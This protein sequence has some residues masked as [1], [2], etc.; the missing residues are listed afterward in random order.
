MEGLRALA[1]ASL[2]DQKFQKQSPEYEYDIAVIDTERVATPY[3]VAALANDGSIMSPGASSNT[4]R[5]T[6]TSTS[7]VSRHEAGRRTIRLQELPEFLDRP[8]ALRLIMLRRDEERAFCIARSGFDSIWAAMRANP[9]AL[10][11]V[12]QEYDGYHHFPS[13]EPQTAPTWFLGMSKYAL[14][15]TFDCCTSSTT[16]LFLHRKEDLLAG[17]FTMLDIYKACT[18][19]PYLIGFAM[20]LHTLAYFSRET[21]TVE[22]VKTQTIEQKVGFGPYCGGSDQSKTRFEIQEVTGWSR[23]VGEVQGQ[24]A[25][26]HRHLTSI[27]A[28]L[29]AL[30]RREG[31]EMPRF[32]ASTG[33]ACARCLRDTDML[34]EALPVIGSQL[35]TYVDFVEYLKDRA[36]KLSH[37]VSCA[38]LVVCVLCAVSAHAD[39]G[40]T[41]PSSSPS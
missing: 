2:A 26:K 37:V 30:E 23:E 28:M 41:M 13:N 14:L 22:L 4:S 35:A 3:D 21:N 27:R 34:A 24:L 20:C 1:G 5:S 31:L 9:C 19:T 36:G 7:A 29:D 16:A 33:S 8:A 18:H 12:C 17:L 39:C 32:R 11:L 25:N 15:W 38:P 40:H 6:S 10:V